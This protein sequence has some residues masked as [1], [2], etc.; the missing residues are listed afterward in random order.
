[1][2]S[3]NAEL[4]RHTPEVL[5]HLR[6]FRYEKTDDGLYFPTMRAL[7]TGLYVHDVN[8]QDVRIDANLLTDQ[9][10]TYLLDTGI[11]NGAKITSWYL[12]LFGGSVNPAANWTAANFA[13]NASEIVS[14]TEGYAELVRPIFTPGTAAA[15]AI[16]NVAAKAPFTIVTAGQLNVTGAGLLSDNAKG[17]TAG[18]LISATR[19]SSPRVLSNTDVFNLG[20]RAQLAAV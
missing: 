19:F 8:G 4:K 15:N 16:D 6:A 5:R 12:A 14:G 11:G 20:Y 9:G 13:T 2:F 18:K 17:S 3:L 7:A 10:L 1:M